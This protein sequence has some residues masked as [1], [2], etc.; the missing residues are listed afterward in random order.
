MR[1]KKRESDGTGGFRCGV[2]M[3]SYGLHIYLYLM[4]ERTT[5][6]KNLRTPSDRTGNLP[7]V[8]GTF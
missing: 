2:M 6:K 8:P 4:K 3:K 1:E 7:M 5:A